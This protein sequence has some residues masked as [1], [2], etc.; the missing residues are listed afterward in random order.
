MLLIAEISNMHYGNIRKFKR[1]I[2]EA[3]DSG[4]DLIKAQAY[5][6]DAMNGIGSMQYKFYEQCRFPVETYIELLDFAKRHS[7]ELFYTLIGDQSVLQPI[8]EAQNW[9]KIGGF[10]TPTEKADTANTFI[11]YR[12][13]ALKDPDMF[14]P[15]TA[16]A[17]Y[18]TQYNQGINIDDFLTLKE[19]VKANIGVS[20]H[21]WNVQGLVEL[22]KNHNLPAVEKHFYDGKQIKF[23]GKIYRDCFHAINPQ[24]FEKL[25]KDLKK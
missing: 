25:A 7:T 18:A 20:H 9:H 22:S 12:S 6:V 19:R 10:E 8:R 3:R 13:L 1:L 23:Q 4:A 15:K 5:T 11:S 21:F 17:L 16:T 24:Q 2:I 14:Y